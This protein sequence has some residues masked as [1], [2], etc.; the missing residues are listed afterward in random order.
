MG[1]ERSDKSLER[2]QMESWG[3]KRKTGKS[4]VLSLPISIQTAD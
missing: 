3:A 1:L 4:T 2:S